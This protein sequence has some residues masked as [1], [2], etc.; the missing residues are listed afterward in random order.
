[1]T[2][3]FSHRLDPIGTTKLTQG[4]KS[5]S[6]RADSYI[7]NVPLVWSAGYALRRLAN[8]FTIQF[9]S[10]HDTFG[11]GSPHTS[12]TAVGSAPKPLKK[13]LEHDSALTDTLVASS[14]LGLRFLHVQ[15]YDFQEET[16]TTTYKKTDDATP[17]RYRSI[18]TG[19]AKHQVLVVAV[20][21]SPHNLTTGEIYE[22]SD[23]P[24]LFS[25]HQQ[26][27]LLYSIADDKCCFLTYLPAPSE[28]P[29]A[30]EHVKQLSAKVMERLGISI[31]P[32]ESSL[33]TPLPLPLTITK[34]GHYCEIL[35]VSAIDSEARIEEFLEHR[36]HRIKEQSTIPPPQVSDEKS[37]VVEEPA[38]TKPP[39][40]HDILW[41][42]PN[43]YVVGKQ[44]Y[45]GVTKILKDKATPENTTSKKLIETRKLLGY[46]LFS[47]NKD[48]AGNL[49][50]SSEAICGAI[51]G[52]TKKV[53]GNNFN[54]SATLSL[55]DP[56]AS[57]QISKPSYRNNLAT[58]LETIEFSEEFES[59]WTEECKKLRRDLVW[60]SNGK[61]AQGHASAVLEYQR[62][63]ASKSTTSFPCKIAL[64]LMERLNEEK[65][66]IFT[67]IYNNGISR[68]L[69]MVEEL[70]LESKNS[71]ISTLDKI[72]LQPI[73]I[74]HRT[75][76]TNRLSQSGG[77]FS[78]SREIRNSFFSGYFWVDIKHSQLSIN[79]YLW[80]CEMLQN[81]LKE[82][83]IW[84]Y[85]CASSGL[86]KTDAKAG[87]M[88]LM[89]ELNTKIP[90]NSP[91]TKLYNIPEITALIE[92]KK[93]YIKKILD[94]GYVYDAFENKLEI[95]DSNISSRFPSISQSYEFLLL[96]DILG[97]TSTTVKKTPTPLFKF[98]CTHL[99]ASFIHA[100][101]DTKRGWKSLSLTN[102]IRRQWI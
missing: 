31:D 81:K 15:C 94:D 30:I 22:N 7:A 62:E 32:Q 74:Y 68:A 75:A 13:A 52:T 47:K 9:S 6:Y 96:E 89:Y 24:H 45:D 51:Y 59:L 39:E 73:P 58:T 69:L 44:F 71:N 26:K 77:F 53:R 11:T 88:L 79:S 20:E 85:L 34:R 72:R 100:T 16:Y 28:Y 90:Q 55:L 37:E 64:D 1:M 50:L 76:K 98:S 41:S 14:L 43:D 21:F 57:L 5:T 67:K 102:L 97:I 2:P 65:P 92:S 46:I 23:L 27:H 66:N 87:L 83:G 93:A 61:S 63:K 3:S 84:P 48:K 19:K 86:T 82:G 80:G 70:D 8:L 25:W 78:L 17:I 12:V 38:P 99:M 49:I 29:R 42:V 35:N 101:K 4:K 40:D 95:T 91:Y 56:L 33:F 36:K 10:E 18:T 60:L 54:L